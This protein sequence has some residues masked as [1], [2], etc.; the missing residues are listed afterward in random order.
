MPGAQQIA[1]RVILGLLDST[2][3][4]HTVCKSALESH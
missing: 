1:S 2:D 3:M 4:D